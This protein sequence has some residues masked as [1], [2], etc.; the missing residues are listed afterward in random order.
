MLKEFGTASQEKLL[1]A[2]VLVIGAGGLGCPALQY[3]A[4]AGVGCLGVVDDDVVDMG[5]LQRQILYTMEDVGKQKALVAAER[6]KAMNPGVTINALSVRLN[7][8]NAME[9]ISPYDLVIDGSDNFPTRYLVNDACMLAGI[10]LVYGSVFRFE[11]QVAVFNLEWNAV[12]TNYRDL[13]PLPPADAASFSCTEAGV[14]GVVPG[15]IGILQ[16]GEAIKIISGIGEPLANRLCTFNLLRNEWYEVALSPDPLAAKMIPASTEE[17]GRMN[18]DWFCSMGVEGIKEITCDEFSAMLEQDG[19]IAIDV[20]EFNEQPAVDEFV[21][22]QVPLSGF[23]K[24]ISRLEADRKIILFCQSGL[25][26]MKAAEMLKINR[27]GKNIYSLKGGIT[28]WKKSQQ[29]AGMKSPSI[30]PN[31]FL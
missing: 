2:S 25:R 18:Y 20:R 10:P 9:I 26:S 22:L 17:L 6:L 23:E 28:A 29:E 8:H 14:L 4:A 21:H 12:K 31:R 19:V 24:A 7:S 3:L 13:F 16:A 27:T 30:D 1:N 11:G 5:N 15:I